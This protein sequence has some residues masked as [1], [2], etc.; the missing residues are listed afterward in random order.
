M[1]RLINAI[2]KIAEKRQANN[3]SEMD[4][5]YHNVMSNLSEDVRL[6]YCRRL[7]ERTKYEIK[8]EKVNES[9]QLLEKL[10]QAAE[11]EIKKITKE[12]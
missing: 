7:I 5:L 3:L 10:I 11:T 8:H 4:E 12:K 9:K 1:K 6:D 2:K